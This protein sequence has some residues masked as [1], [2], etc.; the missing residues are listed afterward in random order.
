VK[1]FLLVMAP[2]LLGTVIFALLVLWGMQIDPSY[3]NPDRLWRG[4]LFIV[5]G[6]IFLVGVVATIATLSHEINQCH[7]CRVRGEGGGGCGPY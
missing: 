2:L 1:R 7:C 6:A 3:H 4:S 5:G